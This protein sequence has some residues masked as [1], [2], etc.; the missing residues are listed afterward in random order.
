M[1]YNSWDRNFKAPFGA[2]KTSQNATI[3]VKVNKN[4]NVY[5]IKLIIEKEDE[6]LKPVIVRELDL[7]QVSEYNDTREY[8]V[9][10]S[11]LQTPAVYYYFFVVELNIY[12]EDRTLFYGKTHNNGMACEYTYE[13]LNKYQLTVYEDYKVPSWFKEGIL[14]HVFVDRLIFNL[15]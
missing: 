15:I 3:K 12:G 10:I 7:K 4:F 8:S 5:S 9:E 14:Y 1:R 6:N 11:P 13:N 2:L